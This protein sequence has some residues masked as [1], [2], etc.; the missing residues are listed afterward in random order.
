MKFLPAFLL[1]LIGAAPIVH[2][3]DGYAPHRPKTATPVWQASLT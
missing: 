1:L 2:A 3:E